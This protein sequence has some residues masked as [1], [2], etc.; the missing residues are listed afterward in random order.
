METC[1]SE[2]IEKK[3]IHLSVEGFPL[4]IAHLNSEQVKVG[5]QKKTGAAASSLLAPQGSQNLREP[6]LREPFFQERKVDTPMERQT[7]VKGQIQKISA[8]SSSFLL[9]LG[10]PATLTLSGFIC[11]SSALSGFGW[12]L[13][14]ALAG[15]LASTIF[16]WS[17]LLRTLVPE[18][19]TW[20][21]SV[22]AGLLLALG[23][24]LQGQ[25]LSTNGWSPIHA[26]ALA[27]IPWSRTMWRLVAATEVLP[28]LRSRLSALLMTTAAV[29]YLWPEFAKLN[30]ATVPTASTFLALPDLTQVTLPLPRSLSFLSALCF[31]AASSLQLAQER[32]ISSLTF[33]SIP[34]A[35]AAIT[36]S[37][38]GWVAL[39]QAST[40]LE[41]MGNLDF[42]PMHRLWA[43][44]PAF[45]FGIMM[46][47]LRPR[48][49]IKNSLLV[50]RETNSWWQSLGLGAGCAI[51]LLFWHN[52]HLFNADILLCGLVIVGQFVGLRCNNNPVSF[53]PRLSLVTETDT[54]PRQQA[55]QNS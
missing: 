43:V 38:I 2:T 7:S 42:A 11:Q 31:G 28:H 50:G 37:L 47:A 1:C 3:S 35:V 29:V 18:R 10:L 40:R 23:L 6:V 4:D 26:V 25:A 49:H 52:T 41:L 44:S 51:T 22:Y 21:K 53:A 34:T 17:T 16:G 39:Q 36:L 48:I 14:A 27:F 19:A 15:C 32:S 54:P 9:G 46:L 24:V 5:D 8:Q 30:A 45:I 12:A 55:L 13:L 20:K 33:W